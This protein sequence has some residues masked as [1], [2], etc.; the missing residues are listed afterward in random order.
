MRASQILPGIVLQSDQLSSSVD[1]AR[2]LLR[3]PRIAVNEERGNA[4][5]PDGRRQTSLRR[6]TEQ[7]KR[8]SMRLLA[9]FIRHGGQEGECDTEPL[10][11]DNITTR[12]LTVGAELAHG[13]TTEAE[14]P[15]N[16]L[17]GRRYE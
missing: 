7:K 6:S 17:V 12:A 4:S 14:R 13:R 9:R 1:N 15:V 3:I 2:Q 11:G 8:A 16:V 10:G 5:L